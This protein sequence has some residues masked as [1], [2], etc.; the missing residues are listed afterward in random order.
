LKAK[1]LTSS[2]IIRR[3]VHEINDVAYL[4][5]SARDKR[6]D[7]AIKSSRKKRIEIQKKIETINNLRLAKPDMN[8]WNM[9]DCKDFIQYKKAKGDPKMPKTLPL[10]LRRCRELCCRGSPDCSQHD[11]DDDLE[12]FDDVDYDDIIFDDVHFDDIREI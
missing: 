6:K 9:K 2:V 1:K 8:S 11:S 12:E 3:R 4:I 7:T 5:R 10:L